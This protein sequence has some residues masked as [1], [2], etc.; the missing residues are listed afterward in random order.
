MYNPLI[1]NPVTDSSSWKLMPRGVRFLHSFQSLKPT[2]THENPTLVGTDT[3]SATAAV[4]LGR[5]APKTSSLG[6]VL[7][8]GKLFWIACAAVM[9]SNGSAS[10]SSKRAARII[11]SGARGRSVYPGRLSMFVIRS[12]SNTTA[13]GSLP[14]LTFRLI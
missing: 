8:T 4:S 13:S 7:R 6:S 11:D 10:E 9:R 1:Y 14:F 12:L 2:R 3:Y 5:R